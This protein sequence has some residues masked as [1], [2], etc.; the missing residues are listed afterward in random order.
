[1]A[2]SLVTTPPIATSQAMGGKKYFVN[3]SSKSW[4]GIGA[5]MSLSTL[6]IHEYGLKYVWSYFDVERLK[7]PYPFHIEWVAESVFVKYFP[8]H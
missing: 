8:K 1:M 7:C 2:C 5:L 4:S 6:S 3:Q